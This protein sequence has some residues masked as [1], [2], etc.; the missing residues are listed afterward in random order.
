MDR[1]KW[2]ILIAVCAV[3]LAAAVTCAVVVEI[4][5]G[6]RQPTLQ[7]DPT[8]PSTEAQGTLPSRPTEPPV[9][10]PPETLP[11]ETLPQ[12]QRYTLTFVGD[13]TLGTMPDWMSYEGCFNNVVG[14]NY[15]YPFQNVAELFRDDDCTFANLEGVFANGGTPKIKR[16]TFRGPTAYVNILTGSSVEAVTLANN[17]SY[18]FG[19]AGYLSTKQVLTDA[20][21]DFVE[22]NRSTLFSTESGLIIGM[23]AANYTMD[24]SDMAAQAADLRAR[25]AEIVILALHCGDEGIYTANDKQIGYAHAAIDAG[26]DIVW[27]HHPHVLQRI[28]EYNGGIIYYSLGNFSFGGNHNP[29]D[30]DTAILRQEIIRRADGTV[31]LGVLTIVPCR[32]SSVTGWNDFRPTPMAEG[33]EEYERVLQK[34]GGTFTGPDIPPNYGPMP[35][36]PTE[37]QPTEPQPTQPQPTEPEPTVPEPTQPA[38]PTVP[39]EPV[40]PTEPTEP[41][42]PSEPTVPPEPTE[43]SEPS[44]PTDDG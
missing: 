9:T 29:R 14:D 20:G 35:T 43:P 3:I 40:E 13:C 30:K 28:E 34:L 26:V 31:E 42:E 1:K 27:G 6:S 21:V 32:L 23:Y 44:E 18:D 12:E 7:S 15:D 10:Q 41:S 8:V 33:T 25:G 37:P 38:E 39:T 24:V 19:E 11:P 22:A 5:R 2:I 17:H 36:A 16:F 4:S